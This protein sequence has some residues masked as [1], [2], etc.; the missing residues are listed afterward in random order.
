MIAKVASLDHINHRLLQRLDR[1]GGKSLLERAPVLSPFR[2]VSAPPLHHLPQSPRRK[3]SFHPAIRDPHRVFLPEYRAWKWAGSCSRWYMVI[4]MPRNRQISGTGQFYLALAERLKAH[5]RQRRS[6]WRPVQ[7]E[8][9]RRLFQ[10]LPGNSY[11]S[12]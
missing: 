12:G 6:R 5:R 4:T 1:F 7:R 2:T 10:G 9:R 11:S 3:V 8:V